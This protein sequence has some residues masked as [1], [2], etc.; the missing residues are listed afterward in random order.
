MLVSVIIPVYNSE[1]Y[2]AETLDSILASV[3]VNMEVVC[4]DD[5]SQDNSLEILKK[6][7]SKDARVRVYS[8][9][10]AGACVARNYAISLAKGEFIL[11]I[12]SDDK[13]TP[14]YI[15]NATKVLVTNPNV[16]VVIPEISC[17]IG[18]FT[19]HFTNDLL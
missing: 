19:N 15:S 18:D 13:I 6:Y 11:P 4:V 3:Y 2:I 8:Q 1:K 5:G 16:K 17:S 7:A 9:Q 10:N 12:D 14:T